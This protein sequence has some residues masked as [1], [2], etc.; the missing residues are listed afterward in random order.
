MGRPARVD[1]GGG[2]RLPA[3]LAAVLRVPGP[4]GGASVD[5]LQL[6]LRVD[7]G[8]HEGLGPGDVVERARQ[9]HDAGLTGPIVRGVALEHDPCTRLLLQSLDH[10]ASS[11]GDRSHRLRRDL[12]AISWQPLALPLA[13]VGSYRAGATLHILES[14]AIAAGA[15]VSCV[16]P[17]ASTTESRCRILPGP[18]ATALWA[19]VENLLDHAPGFGDARLWSRERQ[20]A[21]LGAITILTLIAHFQPRP[22]LVL[23]PLDRLAAFAD[24]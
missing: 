7:D 16:L 12:E 9:A 20:G 18:S 15:L 14:G 8:L 2:R 13:C 5:A 22:T 11:A 10:F 19:T 6:H 3:G 1:A 23:Q 21:R 17:G 24:D 4:V